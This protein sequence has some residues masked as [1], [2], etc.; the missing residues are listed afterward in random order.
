MPKQ[1]RHRWW[2]MLGPYS[3]YHRENLDTRKRQHKDTQNRAKSHRL[4]L[5][6]IKLFT[7][8]RLRF[9]IASQAALMSVSANAIF[10]NFF[11]HPLVPSLGL[12]FTAQWRKLKSEIFL[13]L[14]MNN[15]WLQ[16]TRRLRTQKLIRFGDARF[17]REGKVDTTWRVIHRHIT[18]GSFFRSFSPHSFASVLFELLSALTL[19][20]TMSYNRAGNEQPRLANP[21]QVKNALSLGVCEKR[22]LPASKFSFHCYVFRRRWENEWRNKSHYSLE[23]RGRK[24]VHAENVESSWFAL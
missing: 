7:C 14:Y 16:T 2:K 19:T 18:K 13:S 3:K 23:G 6:K 5:N 11:F 12:V 10:I 8:S 17:E 20:H 22:F 4:L 15:W 1:C 24:N 21:E 9:L